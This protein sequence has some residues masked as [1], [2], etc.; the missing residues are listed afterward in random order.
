MR[1]GLWCHDRSGYPTFFR[2]IKNDLDIFTV[3]KM[4]FKTVF[5][6]FIAILCLQSVFYIN[7]EMRD[8]ILSYTVASPLI[9]TVRD[10][11]K[12]SPD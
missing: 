10:E 1:P 7:I 2:K 3:V 5:E 4:S 11:L 6:I 12:P 9:R 8:S